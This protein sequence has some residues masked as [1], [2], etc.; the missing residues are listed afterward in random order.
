MRAADVTPKPVDWLWYPYVPLGKI[1]AV[2]GQM[3]QAKSLATI[4]LAAAVT[5]GTGLDQDTPGSVLMLNA[6]DDAADTVVPR[7]IAASADLDR[8]WVEPSVT[9]DADHLAR[10]CDQNGNVRLIT[11]DPIAAYL[12][13][14]VNT[15]KAA[16]VRAA[17]EP[18][19]VLAAERSLAVVLVQHLNRRS[20]NGDPLARIADSQGLT[21]LAR[22]VLVWGPDP[23]DPDGDQGTMKALTRAKGNLARAAASATFTITERAIGHGITAPYLQRGADRTITAEEVVSDSD[24]R[25]AVEE[26]TDFLAALLADGPVEAKSV[27]NSA[28]DAGI[29]D[30]TLDRAKRNLKVRSEQAR[31][32][33]TIKGWQWSLPIYPPGDVD[34]VGDLGDLD[35]NANNANN[36]KN[37]NTHRPAN[38]LTADCH[39]ESRGA[40]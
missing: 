21:Q 12:G 30:R 14:N 20:D 35:N 28:K 6:E 11:V 7:L 40:A 2:A 31:D 27:R 1:T 25:T 38:A 10:L 26:A 15:W 36:A 17:L 23:A 37:A 16:D 9:L 3:G 18:L 32:G 22:S 13:G 4:Y 39:D 8:V 5:N 24:T 34:N 19:R 33:Q 29:A